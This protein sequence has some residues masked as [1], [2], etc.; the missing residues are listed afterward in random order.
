M[1]YLFCMLKYIGILKS[2]LGNS[3]ITDSFG[4]TCS[5]KGTESEDHWFI[6]SRNQE[7]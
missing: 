6:C 5:V 7:S 3:Q 1:T 4:I 2:I